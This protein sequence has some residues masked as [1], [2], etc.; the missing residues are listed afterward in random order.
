MVAWS[1]HCYVLDSALPLSSGGVVST[2][3]M[4]AATQ[5][6]LGAGVL[7]N[8]PPSGAGVRVTTAVPVACGRRGLIIFFCTSVALLLQQLVP[9]TAVD[10]GS[11]NPDKPSG[12]SNG[13]VILLKSHPLPASSCVHSVLPSRSVLWDLQVLGVRYCAAVKLGRGQCD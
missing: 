10:L 9:L 1:C 4:V 2:T 5:V 11:L 3:S 7:S 13:F 12:A 8:Y 6:P